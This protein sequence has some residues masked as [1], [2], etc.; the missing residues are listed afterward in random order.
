MASSTVD[1]HDWQVPLT[2]T[3][4][5]YVPLS[6]TC[7]VQM[8]AKNHKT[9][10][11][12]WDANRRRPECQPHS[13]LCGNSGH[14]LLKPKKQFIVTHFIFHRLTFI[15]DLGFLVLV[16][17]SLVF[18]LYYYWSS[19]KISFRVHFCIL[20]ILKGGKDIH[21]IMKIYFWSSQSN[22]GICLSK[23]IKTKT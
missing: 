21:F 23:D 3:Q 16:L 20:I 2:G 14:I 6:S 9:C 1:P 8:H 4:P 18:G 11:S 19:L 22:S 13:W 5:E 12:Q 15:G 17:F 7:M 10:C